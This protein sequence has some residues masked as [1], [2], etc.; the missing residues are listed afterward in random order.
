MKE[1]R[2]G[3]ASAKESS[4]W[5]QLR[6]MT[7]RQIRKALG[8]DPEV[9]PT[10]RDFWKSAQVVMPRAKE[11][12]TIRLDADVLGWFRKQKGYQTRI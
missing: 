6:A 4:D 8:S 1:K 5:K 9:Q 12:I 3:V 2:T 11:T 7:D 10:D